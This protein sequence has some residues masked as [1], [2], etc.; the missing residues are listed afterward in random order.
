MSP[1]VR[2]TRSVMA[3]CI[4]PSGS[5]AA[6]SKSAS[7]EAGGPPSRS[8]RCPSNNC[9]GADPLLAP[10]H[11]TNDGDVAHHLQRLLLFLQ[12]ILQLDVHELRRHSCPKST[13]DPQFICLQVMVA[14]RHFMTSRSHPKSENVGRWG[15]SNDPRKSSHYQR[16]IRDGKL[17]KIECSKLQGAVA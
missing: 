11:L 6:F 2:R 8:C 1:W 16:P 5:N 12:Y 10:A 9:P 15:C 4:R 13:P 17:L 14:I 7:L 3:K